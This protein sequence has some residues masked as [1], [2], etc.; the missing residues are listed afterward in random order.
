MVL[1]LLIIGILLVLF[2]FKAIKKEKTSFNTVL[3]AAEEDM[4]E[5]EV[6]LGEIR[7]EFS[8]TILEL[9]KEIQE[10]K[11]QNVNEIYEDYPK[12]N[13]ILGEEIK[14]EKLKEQKPPKPSSVKEEE[15]LGTLNIKLDNGNE[16]NTEK[17]SV[18]IEEINKLLAKGLSVDDVSIKLGIGKGE[19]LLI[20]ELYLR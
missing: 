2:N 6:R 5:F 14:E 1:F 17:N 19:V 18:K 4:T 11:K 10:L 7:R 13:K 3:H 8:E 20:K 9:Q 16:K 15:N 12:E